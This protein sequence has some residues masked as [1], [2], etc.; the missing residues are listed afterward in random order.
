[1][2]KRDSCIEVL[3]CIYRDDSFLTES[4]FYVYKDIKLTDG[5]RD[6]A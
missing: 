5:G 6:Y 4:S 1:M 3:S 2:I